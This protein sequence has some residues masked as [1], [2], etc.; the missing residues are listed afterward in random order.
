VSVDLE[1]NVI[2]STDPAGSASAWTRTRIDQRNLLLAV[3]CPSAS[4]CVTGDQVGNILTSTDPTDD[5][6]AWTSAPV[7]L[8]GCNL[9]SAP[10][11]SEQLYARDD[12]RTRLVDAA[13]PG[14]GNSIGDVALAGELLIL[15]WTHDGAARTL[16]LR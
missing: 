12:Q 14:Q 7:D 2:T 6:N 1:G 13:P 4:L 5:A 15:S 11:I 9:Q 10:C 3:S 8:P 16:A